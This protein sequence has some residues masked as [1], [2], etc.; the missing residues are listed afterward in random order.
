VAG[1]NN[2]LLFWQAELTAFD[3]NSLTQR[4]SIGQN[5]IIR[6]LLIPAPPRYHALPS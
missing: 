2:L 4:S 3:V 6:A 1:H 5:L